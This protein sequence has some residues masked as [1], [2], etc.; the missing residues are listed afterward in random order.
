[1]SVFVSAQRCFSACILVAFT[2]AE[3]CF[4]ACSLATNRLNVTLAYSVRTTNKLNV[5]HSLGALQQTIQHDTPVYLK[6]AIRILCWD[7]LIASRIPPGQVLG[8]M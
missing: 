3:Q 2:Y 6:V 1:M 5:K 8:N 4:S 7:N